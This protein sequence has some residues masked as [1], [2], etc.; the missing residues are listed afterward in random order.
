[1]KK[2]KIRKVK[3]VQHETPHQFSLFFSVFAKKVSDVVGSPIVFMLA[4]VFILV[5]LLVGPYFHYSDAW[6]LVINTG[7]TIVTFLIV[8]LIQHTQNRDAEIINLKIDELIK[9]H[10]GARDVM[11]KKVINPGSS[12]S[13]FG[14][15]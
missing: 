15:C 5:W 12:L 4:L 9:G 8:F 7:T 3:D 2:R 10:K 13:Y 6:Q 11:P 14:I 1:M